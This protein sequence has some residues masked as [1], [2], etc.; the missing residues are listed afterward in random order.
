MDSTPWHEAETF[1]THF[2]IIIF[3][4]I[5]RIASRKKNQ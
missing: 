4:T 5:H 1:Y 2:Q 3:V